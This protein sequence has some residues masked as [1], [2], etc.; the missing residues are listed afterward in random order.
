MTRQDL[1]DWERQHGAI[2]SDTILLRRTGFSRRWP[3]AATYLGTT[4]R[5]EAALTKLHFPGLH[6][7]AARWIV[8][9][10]PVKASMDS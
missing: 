9:S 6:P 5:G 10:R 2:S 7:D 4:E 3:N 1:K 8:T